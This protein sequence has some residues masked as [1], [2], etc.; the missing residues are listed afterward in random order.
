MTWRH[1]HFTSLLIHTSSAMQDYL[2]STSALS[3]EA[4]ISQVTKS[5]DGLKKNSRT[6][7]NQKL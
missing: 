6:A 5:S 2:K 7:N 1:D 4:Y 3:A